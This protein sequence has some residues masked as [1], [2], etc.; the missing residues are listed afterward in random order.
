[1]SSARARHILVDTEAACLDL[2]TRI[3]GGEDF[4]ELARIHSEDNVSRANGGDLGWVTPGE[5]SPP[6]E[7]AMNRLRVGEISRPVRTP[8]GIHLIE[9]IDR[10]QHDAGDEIDRIVHYATVERGGYSQLVHLY[11]PST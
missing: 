6:F 8:F 4:A 3:E 9:V 11:L 7:E 10:R 2:K 5:M 1:M